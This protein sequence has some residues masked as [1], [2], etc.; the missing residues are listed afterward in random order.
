MFEA[1]LTVLMVVGVL[2]ID[3]LWLKV[4]IVVGYFL[5]IITG[6]YSMIWGAPFVLTH[7]KKLPTI[8][9]V[10]DFQKNDYVVDLGAGDGRIVRV[11]AGDGVKKVVGYEY[12]VLNYLFAR[13]VHY[14]KKGKGRIVF[15]DFWKQEYKDVDVVVC[16]LLDKTI[17]DVEDLIW[18]KLRKGARL[19]SHAFKMKNVKPVKSKNGIHLYIKGENII[20]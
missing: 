2:Y 18:P 17:L 12:S 3:I 1:V 4:V 9:E 8:L 16:F 14:F 5:L 19:I 7:K 15:G 6:I 10:G 11:I 13:T 20:D